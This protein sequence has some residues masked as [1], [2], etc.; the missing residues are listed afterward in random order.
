MTSPGVVTKGDAVEEG[1]VADAPGAADV[2]LAAADAAALGALPA[3]EAG[4]DEFEVDGLVVAPGP[5]HAV[6][7]T[8]LATSR[9][10]ARRPSIWTGLNKVFLSGHFYQ[11]T[12]LSQQTR[13]GRQ[14]CQMPK[15]PLFKGKGRRA[16]ARRPLTIS[17]RRYQA[18]CGW[19]CRFAA[20]CARRA[21][22]ATSA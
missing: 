15:G 12:R 20:A 7:M 21:N 2:G 11:V 18:D 10:A 16:F 17:P 19:P 1:A 13:Y 14:T 3:V 6:A 22:S 8:E 5:T 4:G 9:T